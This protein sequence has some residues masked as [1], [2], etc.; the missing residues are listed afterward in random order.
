MLKITSKDNQ[1]IKE[2]AKLYTSKRARRESGCFVLE[3]VRLVCDTAFAGMDIPFLFV[4]E[5]GIRR[6]GDAFSALEE[7][8]GEAFLIGDSLAEKLGDT[9]SPQGVFAVCREEII[10]RSLPKEGESCL[11]L[12]SLQDPGNV[13]TVL[14]SA[15]AFAVPVVL[16][17]DCPDI[18]SPKVLRAAMGVRRAYVTDDIC[19]TIRELRGRKMK[20]WAAALGDGSRSV[21]GV[22]LESSAVVIGNEGSG[23]PQS[24]I[25][26][27]DA[28]V[29][30]PIADG[31]ESLNAAAAA[32][33][34]AWELSRA[35]RRTAK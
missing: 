15:A 33:I 16:T 7:R 35:G 12:S 21:D 25:D 4:T 2:L 30:L 8:V 17:S 32:T 22:E 29:I 6:L 24:I 28:P 3:G 27:C 23:L 5:D 14:R 20:V 34:F 19:E 31:C 26:L 11:I 1:R 13:G 10:S 18:T 9:A